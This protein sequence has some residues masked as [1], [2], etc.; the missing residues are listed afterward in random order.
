GKLYAG[1]GGTTEPRS[2]PGLSELNRGGPPTVADF[3]DDGRPEIGVAGGYSYAVFDMN[4][5]GEDV[6]AGSVPADPGAGQLFMR[7]SQET[8]D[9]S[10]NASGSSVFDFQGDGAAEVIYADECYVRAYD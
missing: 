8:Q 2:L 6:P 3:D 4:R 7:W 5:P 10:A 1:A 9:L